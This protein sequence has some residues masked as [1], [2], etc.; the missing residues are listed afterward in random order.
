MEER[1][2]IG[3]II[4]SATIGGTQ[5]LCAACAGDAFTAEQLAD[6]RFATKLYMSGDRVCD[7]CERPIESE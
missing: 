4:N 3:Y 5:C 7:E 6:W 2:V 1:K